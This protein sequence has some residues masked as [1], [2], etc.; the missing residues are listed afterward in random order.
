MSKMLEDLQKHFDS[1]EHK[2]WAKEYAKKLR[3][4]EERL[5][6]RLASFHDKYGN[7]LDAVLERL[8]DKY[9]SDEYVKREYSLGY[10]PRER[11]LWFVFEYAQRY[12]KPCKDK[13]YYND[14]TGGAYYV[15]SYVMQIMFGQGSVLRID[16]RKK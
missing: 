4:S 5:K 12:C 16:K 13:R 2:A 9:Y 8:M 7:N 6:N 11:L 1:P 14:F 15:G 10:Q 3:D